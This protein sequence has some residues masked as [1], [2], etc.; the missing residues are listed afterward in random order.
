MK[1]NFLMHGV[2]LQNRVFGLQALLKLVDPARP[3]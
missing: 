2:V 3:R 1:G